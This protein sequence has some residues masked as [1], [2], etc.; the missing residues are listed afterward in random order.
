MAKYMIN[1]S[2]D[3][4]EAAA[5]EIE[6]RGWARGVPVNEA[7]QVCVLGALWSAEESLVSS[8]FA[9][10]D[11]QKYGEAVTQNQYTLDSKSTREARAVIHEI[12][13][14]GNIAVWND[15]IC[16]SQQQAVDMLREA[17]KHWWEENGS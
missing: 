4:L 5:T 17:A 10:M 16:G 15:Q 13:G 2:A 3:L 12:I 8:N 1:N 14:I 11:Y 6:T 9:D 7:D